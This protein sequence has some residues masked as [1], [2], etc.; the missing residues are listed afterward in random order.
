M[1]GWKWCCH[2]TNFFK[3]MHA[4]NQGGIIIIVSIS[5]LQF[6]FCKNTVNLKEWVAA[7][8]FII[9]KTNYKE[10]INYKEKMFFRNNYSTLDHSLFLWVFTYY[11]TKIF[12]HLSVIA[13]VCYFSVHK[14]IGWDPANIYL[15]KVNSRILEKR[16]IF[17]NC[18]LA[19]PRSTLGHTQGDSLTN[20][21]LII[22]TRRLPEPRNEVES[23]S[24]AERLVGLN[25]E[26]SISNHNTLTH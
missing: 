2:I 16:V 9:E 6:L 21:I 1:S 23:L 26:P 14:L 20:C 8:I 19:A 25:R 17:F 10:R 3:N 15:F 13:A 7:I 18:C 11:F 4:W 22:L 5:L 12:V 24:P